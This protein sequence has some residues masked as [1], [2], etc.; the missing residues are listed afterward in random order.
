MNPVTPLYRS[1][2][3]ITAVLWTSSCLPI[4]ERP[5][6]DAPDS[7]AGDAHELYEATIDPGDQ[8]EVLH[9]PGYEA[10]A[11]PC[12]SHQECDDQNPCT[13]DTCDPVAGCLYDPEDGACQLVPPDCMGECQEGLCVDK[14]ESLNG[15]ND[16]CARDDAIDEDFDLDHDG[17]CT[18]PDECPV[19]AVDTCPTVWNPDNDPSL[20][21]DPD[22]NATG[23]VLL[24]L[25]VPDGSKPSSNARRTN[26]P[27]TIPLRN[28]FID[29]SVEGYWKLDRGLARDYSGHG[30]NG[31]MVGTLEPEAD[32]YGLPDGALQ[33]GTGRVEVP[34]SLAVFNSPAALTVTA[35][36][37][38]DSLPMTPAGLVEK[39]GEDGTQNRS[40]RVW[41]D[42]ASGEVR[43]S[44]SGDGLNI[45]TTGTTAELG[46]GTWMHVAAV[47][48]AGHM[49]L[50][51]NGRL[52][53]TTEPGEAPSQVYDSSGL[54][55]LAIGH[56][57]QGALD[58]VMVFSRGLGPTEVEAMALSNLP[59]GS[60]LLPGGQAD[61][62]DLRVTEIAPQQSEHEIPV[63]VIGVRPHSDSACA[64]EEG[65]L[66]DREDLCGV[67]A[68]W[69]MNGDGDDASGN[70]HHLTQAS[71]KAY[72]TGR[73][74][75]PGGALYL[76]PQETVQLVD[77]ADLH[78]A[79]FTVESWVH[80]PTVG[81]SSLVGKSG[82][83]LSNINYQL[84][85]SQGGSPACRFDR[86]EGTVK[87]TECIAS[88]HLVPAGRWTHLAC[89]YDQDHIR[90]YMDG[91]EVGS[92]EE[93][94]VPTEDGT[95]IFVGNPPALC[96][97]DEVLIHET[98]KS[99]AYFLRRVFRG[100]PV[101]RFLAQTSA[102]PDEGGTHGFLT[103]SLRWGQ[104]AVA[105]EKEANLPLLV[106]PDG[107]R[108]YGL[109]TPC[110]GYGGWW[111]FDEGAGITV[112]DV[113]S[114]GYHGTVAGSAVA[115]WWT[116]GVE[117][118]GLLFDGQHGHV[119]IPSGLDAQSATLEAWVSYGSLYPDT[120]GTLVESWRV[121]STEGSGFSMAYVPK[122]KL[123]FNVGGKEAELDPALDPV[124]VPV[125]TADPTDLALA[126]RYDGQD[127]LVA[128]VGYEVAAGPTNL[129]GR[130]PYSGDQTLY[131]GRNDNLL[132]HKFH[133]GTIDSIRVMDRP[134]EPDEFLRHP[135][136]AWK[137]AVCT[138]NEGTA[139]PD[140][141]GVVGVEDCA[142]LDPAIQNPPDQED[143]CGV[144]KDCDGLALDDGESCEDG[145]AQAW[146]GCDH[147]QIAEYPATLETQG[148]QGSLDES[149]SIATLGDGQ[150]LVSWIAED[151][152]GGADRS[153]V[154]WTDASGASTDSVN[155]WYP[156]FDA[157]QVTVTSGPGDTYFVA[158]AVDQGDVTSWDVVGH[159]FTSNHTKAWLAGNPPTFNQTTAGSQWQP[160]AAVDPEGQVIMSWAS[161]DQD[162]SGWGVFARQT[163]LG[164]A[165]TAEFPV[166]TATEGDQ[167]RP[168][169]AATDA[170]G[171]VV[172]WVDQPA[173]DTETRVKGQ[174]FIYADLGKPPQK[175]GDEFA[176]SG[177]DDEEDRPVIDA[178]TD[179]RFAVTWEARDSVSGKSAVHV[180]EFAADGTPA[181]TPMVI[182]PDDG[183][184]HIRPALSVARDGGLVVVWERDDDGDVLI[185]LFGPDGTPTGEIVTVNRHTSGFQG[186]P[187]VAFHKDGHLRVVWTSAGQVGDGLGLFTQRFDPFGKRV[188]R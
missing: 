9:D 111:R 63:E 5:T 182:S 159:L 21:P 102:F 135:M 67:V 149:G 144:D 112:L 54:T 118:S 176:V 183:S 53:I 133:T 110:L 49:A 62:D 155:T 146:D 68:Y 103:Y 161:Q 165:M 18:N 77:K 156:D 88:S 154:S 15:I 123:N 41:L 48:N 107:A 109:L 99:P 23:S 157:A 65:T 17:V 45:T 140:C 72:G 171:F 172:V 52:A 46:S 101:A 94:A 79:T 30:R 57:F 75:D 87:R 167:T 164:T 6:G 184:N 1:S 180:R 36:F 44:L 158:W 92:C 12:E 178:F 43:F 64:G 93:G 108:C 104:K 98:A 16:D 174:R 96:R 129:A 119:V 91:R 20:C 128:Y 10:D 95:T 126:L 162:G 55:R 145:N 105:P 70:S 137:V 160:S 177:S 139:D 131:V 8:P 58:E 113:T 33:F 132:T 28:G 82:P 37:R 22:P 116:M 66:A 134:L 170:Q 27:V 61:Y 25:T 60:H 81:W 86:K 97:F 50:Y 179:G 147:C 31:T 121:S 4:P 120:L 143:T 26:E 122:A 136:A 130:T 59:F 71:S 152:E 100:L 138:T 69:K 127:N 19:T 78:L 168:S 187:S 29:D 13:A 173:V 56:D 175:V 74:D 38:S 124:A 85:I 7:E 148:D 150:F 89:T 35:W 90:L 106:H 151:P 24:T 40:W 142:P 73:F 166:N 76:A 34:D 188:Y 47:F 14:E 39:W 84:Y 51:L 117:G 83:D 114:N 141:D 163:I 2:L 11:V 169:V 42:P 185:R 3:L 181:G 32:R 186:V 80:C 153:W 125:E 115:P